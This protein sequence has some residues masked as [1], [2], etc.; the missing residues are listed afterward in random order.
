MKNVKCPKNNRPIT[1]SEKGVWN[2]LKLEKQQ[3]KNIG[4]KTAN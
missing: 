4:R 2:S 1:H 3:L